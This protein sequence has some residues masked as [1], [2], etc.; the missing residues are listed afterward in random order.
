MHSYSS[1]HKFDVLFR[2]LV[3]GLVKGHAKPPSFRLTRSMIIFGVQGAL[4]APCAF[5]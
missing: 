1:K 2:N 3:D 5:A 4:Q